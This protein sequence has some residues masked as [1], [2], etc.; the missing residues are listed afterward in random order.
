MNLSIGTEDMPSS[1]E[2]RGVIRGAARPRFR[3]RS[4]D[5]PSAGYR[6]HL[7]HEKV[8]SALTNIVNGRPVTNRAALINPESLDYFGKILPQLQR[9]AQSGG[10]FVPCFYRCLTVCETPITL[11][12]RQGPA[13][14]DKLTPKLT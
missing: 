7:Q 8:E 11:G 1:S 5:Y 13:Q 6:L 2:E 4:A 14:L 10:N 9:I 12:R 3:V